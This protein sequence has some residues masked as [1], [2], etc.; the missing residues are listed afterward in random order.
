MRLVLFGALAILLG[1]GLAL[2]GLAQLAF[3]LLAASGVG[4]PA[5][6]FRVALA[7]CITD[8]LLGAVL[9]WA[10][11]GSV[12]LR[13]WAPVVMRFLAWIWLLGGALGSVLV[14]AMLDDLIWLASRGGAPMAPEVDLVVRAV[15]V[16]G[17]VVAGI[18]VPLAFLVAYRESATRP[19]CEIH[20]PRPGWTDA[21]PPPVLGLCLG[22]GLAALL[23]LPMALHPAVPA[24][25]TWVDGWPGAALTVLGALVAGGLAAAVYRRSPA[26]WSLTTA[27]LLVAGVSCVWTFQVLAPEV[28]FG[29]LGYPADAVVHSSP[30]NGL[31]RPALVWGAILL[32]LLSLGYMASIRRHFGR[33][34]RLASQT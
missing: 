14:L 20:D 10:G 12:R 18:L 13:R 30:G 3:P 27:L 1:A 16:G 2:L 6:G 23:A 15:L 11:I 31:W 19:I 32:T 28:F 17:F 24:F 5:T 29:Y 26:A 34:G 22:L 9:V 25:G 33:R 4:A 7:G 8:L 21:C